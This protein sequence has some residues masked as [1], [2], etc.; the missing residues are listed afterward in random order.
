MTAI[1]VQLPDGSGKSVEPGTP[2]DALFPDISDLV[3]GQTEHVGV[4]VIPRNRST[5]LVVAQR[6]S[7][8]LYLVGGY[9]HPDT[10]A[11]NQN[12]AV[13]FASLNLL[14][15]H[16]G[17]IR[18]VGR[19]LAICA[20]IDEFITVLHQFVAK[21]TAL[22]NAAMIGSYRNSHSSGNLCSIHDTI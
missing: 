9:G 10:R 20:E 1:T 6:R 14:T 12:A 18:I 13:T 15:Y 7:D 16:L 2:A 22:R 17:E 5:Q 21:K 3:A 11:A 4:V 19:F 8:R